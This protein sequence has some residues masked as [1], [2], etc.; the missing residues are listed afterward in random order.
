MPQLAANISNVKADAVAIRCSPS[1]FAALLAMIAAA[2]LVW[3]AHCAAAAPYPTRPIRFIVGPGP[4]V[5]PRLLGQK[6]AET[7]GQQ[8]VVDQ[9]PGAGGIIAADTVAKSAPD[10]YTLLLT[11]GAYTINAS[12]YQKLPYDLERDLAPVGLLATISFLVVVSQSSAAKTMQ[13]LVQLA[14]A[15][16]GGLNC[17]HSGPGTT[18]HLGCEMLK[19]SAGLN[20]VPI[21][22]KGVAPA[23]VD[24]MSG[25]AHLMFAVM[26]GG[27]PHVQAGKLRALAITGPKRSAA[28][29]DLPTIAEAGFRGAD[30]ISWNGVHVRKGTPKGLVARL[31]ADFN[32]ALNLPDVRERMS[33]LGLEPAGGTPEAFGDFVRDDIARWAK[34]IKESGVRVE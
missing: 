21:S 22:Y 19:S 20:I 18:A 15:K 11:T 7:W 10:G 1:R 8:V 29:P 5:L 32:R 13:D 24:V 23:L 6:L 2:M 31:N 9:R 16:P 27:L 34:V 17:A 3:S 33:T 25:Q 30:F 12:L 28:L 4:D 14:K 26:Q